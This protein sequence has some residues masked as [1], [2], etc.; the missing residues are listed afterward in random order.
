[1]FESV[2]RDL[3]ECGVQV[4]EFDV[5]KALNRKGGDLITPGI[6]DHD[7]RRKGQKKK[8]GRKN[9]YYK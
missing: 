4:F 7:A 8:R 3:S 9:K 5:M 2:A 6:D 1:M